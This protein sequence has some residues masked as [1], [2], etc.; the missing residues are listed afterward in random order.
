SFVQNVTNGAGGIVG[1]GGPAGPRAVDV[2]PDG[3]NV[4][5]AAATDG[6]VTAFSP[7]AST[8]AGAVLEAERDRLDRVGRAAGAWSVV[9]SPDG[10]NLYVGSFADQA[11]AVFARDATTG[12][13]AFVEAQKNGVA[14]IVGLDDP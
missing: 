6:A 12:R 14:G 8:R 1:L 7:D 2:S 9:V 10:R 3:R 5:V 4:Y 13:L 11:L